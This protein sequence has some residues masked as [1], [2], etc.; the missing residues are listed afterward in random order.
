[1]ESSGVPSAPALTDELK[2]DVCV[3]GAGIAG[4]TTAYLL[5]LEGKSVVVLDDGPIGGGESERTTAH[6]ATALDS[7]YFL[8]ERLHRPRGACL[9][10]PS[11]N[12][13]I[14]CL[15]ATFAS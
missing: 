10:A 6:L 8:L 11:H 13:A 5:T 3:I 14:P 1:M 15:G 2:A 9:A 4:L 7:R 12:P